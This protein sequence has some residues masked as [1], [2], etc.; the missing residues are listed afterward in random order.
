ME[1]TLL[2]L[3]FIG[4]VLIMFALMRRGWHRSALRAQDVIAPGPMFD[5]PII[6]GPWSGRFLGT[7]RAQRWLDRVNA[8]SLGDRSMVAINVTAAGVNV[9]REGA[10]SFGI[11]AADIIGVRADSGIAGRAYGTAGIVVVTFR[12]GQDELE[13]GVRFPSTSDH[14][15]ALAALASTEVSS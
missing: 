7:T 2:T 5:S 6:A 4:L 3:L 11:P 8:H 13:F 12:L 15:A 9:V 10:L 14:I 1:R